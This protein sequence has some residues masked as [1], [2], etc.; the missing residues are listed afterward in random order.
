[1]TS[2][3]TSTAIALEFGIRR[4][5]D[6]NRVQKLHL[7]K[8]PFCQCC[9]VLAKGEMQVHHKF[10]FHLCVALGRDDLELDERNLI[11]LCEDNG[12]PNHHLLIGHL[13]NFESYNPNVDK[14]IK[15]FA[16]MTQNAIKANEKWKTKKAKRPKPFDQMTTRQKTALRIKMDKIYPKV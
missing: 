6:W 11:T 10:P 13:G 15:T 7:L 3:A 8:Q 5:S 9:G 4:S 1:M 12:S 14:D 16:G 2:N